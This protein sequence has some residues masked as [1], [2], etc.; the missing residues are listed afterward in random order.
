MEKITKE[1]C[2]VPDQILALL[3]KDI[4]EIKV[5]LLGNEYNPAGG[6]LYRV[7]E[8]EK[9]L[10]DMQGEAERMKNKYDRI[11]WTVAGG[12][13][14]IAVAA[15]LIMQWFDKIVMN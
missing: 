14:V 1:M 2:N 5:A 11:L 6:L 15:N 7:A 12:A 13:S 8:L 9:Q 3:Q 4:A 10:D